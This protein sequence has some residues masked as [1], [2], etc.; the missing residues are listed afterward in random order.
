VT[1][2]FIIKTGSGGAIGLGKKLKG[3]R[4]MVDEAGAE[5]LEEAETY[6]NAGN[7]PGARP[8]QRGPVQDERMPDEWNRAQNQEG[9]VVG[10]IGQKPIV[11]PTKG[12]EPDTVVENEGGSESEQGVMAALARL[13]QQ[14]R[15]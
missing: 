5:A 2:P 14:E 15:E 3:G 6:R 13:R 12:N 9:E 11:R 10:F 7:A 8:I 4:W 1:E